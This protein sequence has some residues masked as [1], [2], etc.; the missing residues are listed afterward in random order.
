MNDL[1]RRDWGLRVIFWG[2]LLVFAA[3]TW[4]CWGIW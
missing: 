3:V 1:D 4:L 2:D